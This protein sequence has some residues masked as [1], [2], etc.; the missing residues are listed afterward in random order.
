[1]MAIGTT[2]IDVSAH[3]R[4]EPTT[5]NMVKPTPTTTLHLVVQD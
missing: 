4:F 2:G 1:M 5:N 3:N